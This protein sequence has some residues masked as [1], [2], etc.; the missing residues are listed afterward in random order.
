MQNIPLFM[1][2][3]ADRLIG[4]TLEKRG[5]PFEA[6]LPAQAITIKDALDVFNSA[7]QQMEYEPEMSIDEINAEIS[8][9]REKT[10]TTKEE[11]AEFASKYK[12]IDMLKDSSHF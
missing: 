12:N 9:V 5:L 2:D 6:T 7:R 1:S 3:Q 10:P 4:F 8:A 11:I